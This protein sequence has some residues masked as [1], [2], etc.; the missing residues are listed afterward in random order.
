MNHIEYRA[1]EAA[2]LSTCLDIRGKT[3]DNA[4]PREY[5]ESI[6]IT[7][8]SWAPQIT[9]GEYVG[10]VAMADNQM[11]G[12]CFGDTLGGEVLVL[13]LLADFEGGGVGK[14]LLS[15]VVQMLFD[16]GLER[17]WLAAAPLP[18]MRAYGF[19]RHCGWRPTGEFDDNGD[20]ILELFKSE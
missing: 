15:R 13:A 6:G 18:S 16:S 1:A 10:I 2:D 12:Y 17:L 20:Q 11:V 9:R 8:D 19:Y 3:R 5:L 7:A 4:I 14:T